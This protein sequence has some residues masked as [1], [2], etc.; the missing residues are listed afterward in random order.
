MRGTGRRGAGKHR[1]AITK[2]NGKT[3]GLSASGM[4][5]GPQGLPWV[6]Q[7][8]RP[9]GDVP[10]SYL[11]RD[12]NYVHQAG[13][14][15]WF[16]PLFSLLVVATFV[17]PVSSWTL[18]LSPPPLPP[19]HFLS[20]LPHFISSSFPEC[21]HLCDLPSSLPGAPPQFLET[22]FI[23]SVCRISEASHRFETKSYLN[24]YSNFQGLS[25]PGT[26]HLKRS[27]Y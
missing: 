24:F 15:C 25:P 12:T 8:L 11:L 6:G 17:L 2:T 9:F 13:R 1:A 14:H 26:L 21:F 5:P 27:V 3:P 23:P 20:F 7:T 18:S 22:F 10:A 4:S 19:N 16:S